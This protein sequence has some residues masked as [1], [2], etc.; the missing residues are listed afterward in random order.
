MRLNDPPVPSTGLHALQR[1]TGMEWPNWDCRCSLPILGNGG[2]ARPTP[3]CS[4]V[5][6][7]Q[8]LTP[9]EHM[10]HERTGNWWDLLGVG[11]DCEFCVALGPCAPLPS[12]VVCESGER[13]LRIGSCVMISPL[14]VFNPF[15]YCLHFTDVLSF[16]WSE[17]VRQNF[18]DTAK[19]HFD[20]FANLNQIAQVSAHSLLLVTCSTGW[21]MR[22]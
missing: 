18:V 20:E 3:P 17:I 2:R 1:E 19:K 13:G 16:L 21:F 22:V 15:S 14:C 9:G 4:C 7:S 8:V 6:N 12:L 10:F 5:R 11:G